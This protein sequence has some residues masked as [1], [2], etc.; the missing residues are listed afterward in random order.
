MSAFAAQAASAVNHEFE[1]TSAPA[2]LTGS[3]T[4]TGETIPQVFT[5]S[6][7]AG[8]VTCDAT[9]KGT[10]ELA[11]QDTISLYPEYFNCSIHGVGGVTIAN[12]G[13][14]FKFDS[15]TVVSHAST[16]LDCDHEKSITIEG[17]G[18]T[19]HFSDTHEGSAKTVNQ[20]LVGVVFEN[21]VLGVEKH[22]VE[23][24]ATVTGV[25]YVATGGFCEL[26]GIPPGTN[27]DGVVEG[28]T[29]VQAFEDTS[30]STVEGNHEF[31][32]NN[33]DVGATVKLN[34]AE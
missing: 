22:A 19:I 11:V 23:V 8:V 29:T 21:E 9:F 2:V 20:N 17:P 28:E 15:D 3:S 13:C 27:H 4:V 24:V 7:G 34:T 30:G 14:T 26:L 5:V 6:E 32:H 31:T 1:V 16:S 12:K 18:C 25:T 10:Q 33:V